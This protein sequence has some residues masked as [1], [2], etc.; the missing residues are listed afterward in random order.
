MRKFSLALAAVNQAVGDWEGN[1]KRIFASLCKAKELGACYRLGGELE[2][3]GYNC[4]DH[5]YELDTLKASWQVLEAL[6]SAWEHYSGV[7]VDVGMPVLHHGKTFN[8]RVLALDGRILVIRPKCCLAESG[9]YRESR[10]FS[11]WDLERDLEEFILPASTVAIVGQTSCP[12]GVALV[13]FDDCCI[14]NEICEELFASVQ[15]NSLLFECGAE[16]VLNGSA[17]VFE[18]GKLSRK[19][20]MIQEVCC[21][22]SGFY[23]YC[24]LSGCDGERV[25]FDGCCFCVGSS[26]EFIVEIEPFS[27]KL[28]QVKCLTIDLDAFHAS[29]SRNMRSE[30]SLFRVKIPRIRVGRSLCNSELPISAAVLPTEMEEMEEYGKAASFWLWEHLWKSGASGFFLSLSGGVDSACVLALVHSMCTS[31]VE[32]LDELHVSD[33][34]QENSIDSSSANSVMNGLMHTAYLETLC[35]SSESKQRAKALAN[36]LGNWHVELNFQKAIYLILKIVAAVLGIFV[37]FDRHSRTIENLQ[38][39]LRMVLAYLLAQLI[40]FARNKKHSFLLVLASANVQ[41][42]AVGY[43]TKY[44]CSSADLNPIGSLCKGQIYIFMRFFGEHGVPGESCTRQIIRDVCNATPS[45][46]LRPGEQQSDEQDLGLSFGDVEFLTQ[47]V[48][49]QRKGFASCIEAFK[50]AHK[51]IELVQRFFYL[52]TRNRHK[53]TT[54]TP[55]FHATTLSLDDNRY[56]LRPFLYKNPSFTFISPAVLQSFASQDPS[57]SSSA[58]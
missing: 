23:A 4:Q 14:G 55:S 40:P 3:C 28:V 8:C 39:R 45:A 36:A 5:F 1:W 53:Q 20:R 22:N 37:T 15:V 38:A 6:L 31:I 24:N 9:V 35:N 29:K 50:E 57:K 54:L 11:V 18:C 42:S 58:E 44:D 17:S 26:G 2:V 56:N 34:V 47:L 41:E 30:K 48:F 12:F 43:F 21:R 51:P 33:F 25:L 52:Y 13:D 16:L 10:W 19:R 27:W 7:V 32:N 49:V 46:E